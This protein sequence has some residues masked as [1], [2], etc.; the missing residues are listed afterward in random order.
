[1]LR[2][3][4]L[5]KKARRFLPLLQVVYLTVATIQTG[6]Q[7]Y[8]QLEKSNWTQRSLFRNESVEQVKLRGEQ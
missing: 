8:Q 2:V 6:T 3:N 4:I 1:M 5:S 7:L